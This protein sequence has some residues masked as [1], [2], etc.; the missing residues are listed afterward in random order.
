MNEYNAIISDYQLSNMKLSEELNLIRKDR[1][2]WR[3]LANGMASCLDSSTEASD[4]LQE[5]ENAIHLNK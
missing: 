1:D 5:Y 3:K 4:L 2:F